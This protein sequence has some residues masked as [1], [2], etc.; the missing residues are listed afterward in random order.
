METPAPD[1]P[2]QQRLAHLRRL[3]TIYRDLQDRADKAKADHDRYQAAL[4][5]EMR[6][7]RIDG[8]KHDGAH[9]IPK[10]TI[11]AT[12]QDQDAFEAWCKEQ[13]LEDEFLRASVEKGRLNEL[14]RERL[15][16]AEE[17]PPGVSW[18]S[19]QYIAIT[20]G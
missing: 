8:L 20:Q 13:G 15:N 12:T 19:K 1:S 4:F 3:K 2:I 11:Y 10:E 9:F 18:Y 16:S 5:D 17:L 6:Q 7:D 14:I